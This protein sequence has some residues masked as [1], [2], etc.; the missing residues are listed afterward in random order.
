MKVVCSKAAYFLKDDGPAVYHDVVPF[1]RDYS[2]EEVKDAKEHCGF[3]IEAAN[4]EIDEMEKHLKGSKC[5]KVVTISVYFHV[6]D[7]P[8]YN[9]GVLL[10]R[11]DV[12]QYEDS[13]LFR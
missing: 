12:L 13:C 7:A 11:D 1:D 6:V 10:R 4:R 3:D 2:L 5:V 8:Q 9:F